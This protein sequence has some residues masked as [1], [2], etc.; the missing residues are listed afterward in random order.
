MIPMKEIFPLQ[1]IIAYNFH[2][3]KM[4]DQWGV[5]EFWYFALSPLSNSIGGPCSFSCQFCFP[6]EGGLT[7]L[8]KQQR[9][10]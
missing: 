9:I 8:F 2:M 10:C 7:D 5:S 1:K 4:Y 6:F 3:P